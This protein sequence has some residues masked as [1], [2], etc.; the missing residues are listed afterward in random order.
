M[1]D[2]ATRN[3][4]PGDLRVSD[5]DRDRAVAELSEHFEAGRITADELDERTGRA[6]RARTGKELT[7][8][9]ADLPRH[10]DPPAGT[11]ADPG[12]AGPPGLARKPI[13]RIIIAVLAIAALIGSHGLAAL[14]LPALVVLLFIR[15]RARGG[16]GRD[17]W[18]RDGWGRD[19]WGR[20]GW[21]R[22]GWGHDGWG[23]DGWDRL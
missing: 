6:L 4:P 7:D 12:P 3:Y 14:L 13:P 18:R 20:D 10:E 1:V 19:G 8:L 16:W 22:D 2:S 11:V 15:R 23:H 9:L 17:G 21:R 5:A